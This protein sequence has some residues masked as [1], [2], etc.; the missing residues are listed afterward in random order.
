[1]PGTGLET[2]LEQRLVKDREIHC[3]AGRRRSENRQEYPALPV[4]PRAGR[5]KDEGDEEAQTEHTL[6]DRLPIERIHVC[7]IRGV[8]RASRYSSLKAVL[9]RFSR[10]RNRYERQG[11]LVEEAALARAPY[12]LTSGTFT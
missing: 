9:V 7:I 5:Q 12:A 3:K 6:Y 4:V 1:M 8:R 10:S 2:P 11:V